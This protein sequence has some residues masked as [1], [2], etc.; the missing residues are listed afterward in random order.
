MNSGMFPPQLFEYKMINDTSEEN[1]SQS[2]M[3]I[4]IT[5]AVLENANYWSPRQPTEPKSPKSEA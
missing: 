1:S 2:S 5:W 3:C 4:G